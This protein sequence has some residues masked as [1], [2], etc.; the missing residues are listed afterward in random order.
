MS[1][2]IKLVKDQTSPLFRIKS[3]FNYDHRPTMKMVNNILCSHIGNGYFISVAHNLKSNYQIPIGIPAAIFE[4]N[5]LDSFNDSDKIIISNSYHLHQGSKKYILKGLRSKH[6]QTALTAK[7]QSSKFDTTY[8]YGYTNGLIN[9]YLI[10]QFENNQFYNDS[11]L[12]KL[13]DPINYFNEKNIN[14]HSYIIELEL[15][16]IFYE[17]DIAIYK[18]INTDPKVIHAI[19]KL[20]IDFTT[21]DGTE[22][23]KFYCLQSSPSSEMGRLLNTASIEGI[24]QHWGIQSNVNPPT[25]MEGLRY[26]MKGYF[27]FGSSGAPYLVLKESTGDLK[28]NAVQSEACPQQLLINKSR[29]GN[30]QYINGIATPIGNLEN[31]IKELINHNYVS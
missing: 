24:S 11:A 8:I 23:F 16:S 17:H 1:K 10:V 21:Y 22:N 29:D 19:P 31:Q 7:V 9:P 6:E 15:R 2:L 18:A 3:V 26:I 30:A 28:L 14:K 20:D 4:H 5:F 25:I 13:I 12:T 27:R